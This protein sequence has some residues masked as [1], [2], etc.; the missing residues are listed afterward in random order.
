MKKN[1]LF[2]ALIFSAIISF[3]QPLSV[4]KAEKAFDAKKYEKCVKISVKGIKKDK[5]IIELFYIKTKAEYELSII[6]PQKESET[7]WA[8]ECIKSAIKSKVKDKEN[9]FTNK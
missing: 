2:F 3:A 1:F 9:E 6:V 7:N 5:T 8:K 4:I